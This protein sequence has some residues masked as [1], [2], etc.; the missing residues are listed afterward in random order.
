MEPSVMFERLKDKQDAK[1]FLVSGLLVLL[2][3]IL[4][5]IPSLL[6]YW[7][8]VDEERAMNEEVE[9]QGIG[10]IPGV[11]LEGTVGFFLFLSIVSALAVVLGTVLVSLA[12][13]TDEGTRGFEPDTGKN[14]RGR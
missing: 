11:N 10:E 8:F 9:R 14:S 2:F 6:S 5:F 7:Y 3:G 12:L 1:V 13:M 4:V